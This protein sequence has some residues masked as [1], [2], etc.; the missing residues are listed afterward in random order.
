MRLHDQ[1]CNEVATYRFGLTKLV[2]AD[3][4]L[5]EL[6][7]SRSVREGW[8]EGRGRGSSDNGF[9]VPGGIIDDSLTPKPG[10]TEI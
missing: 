2:C 4:K 9:L 7:D 1:I 5:L 8:G 3:T 6:T 10:R